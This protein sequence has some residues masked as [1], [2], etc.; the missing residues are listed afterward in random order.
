VLVFDSDTVLDFSEPEPDSEP[1]VVL[2]APS[3]FFA[4][5]LLPESP[6]FL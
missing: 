3:V 2:A 5:P 6:L 4:D 1:D